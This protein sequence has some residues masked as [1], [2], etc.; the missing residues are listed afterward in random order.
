MSDTKSEAFEIRREVKHILCPQCH[1]AFAHESVLITD[2]TREAAY[3][4]LLAKHERVLKALEVAE[5]AIERAI[6]EFQWVT[7]G[8]KMNETQHIRLGDAICLLHDSL[9]QIESLK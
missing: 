9:A 3:R 7:N 4:N 1:H 2:D 8:I 6:P 5:A